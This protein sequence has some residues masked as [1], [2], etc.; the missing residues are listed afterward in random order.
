MQQSDSR[1]D[2]PQL[3]PSENCLAW[4]KD[5]ELAVAGGEHV[6]ILGMYCPSGQFYNLHSNAKSIDLVDA[7]R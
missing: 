2:I 5:G 3:S 7:L 4:S 6:V 1:V